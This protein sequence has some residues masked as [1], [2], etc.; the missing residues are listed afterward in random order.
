L[1]CQETRG[2][3]D[4]Y[5]DTELDLVKSLEI[6]KHLRECQACARVYES[7]LRLRSAIKDSALYFKAPAKLHK[8]IQSS[9]RE[10]GQTKA[11]QRAWQWRWLTLGASLAFVAL[12]VL[13]IWKVGFQPGSSPE[14]NLLAQE[15]VSN[16]VRSLMVD[17]LIDVQSSDQHTVK[18]WFDGKLDFSPP[19]TDLTAQGFSLIGG[20]LEY[21]ENRAVAAVVYQRRQ[22]FINLFI[23]PATQ[24]AETTERT[25]TRQG[26]NLIYWNK[27]GMTYWAVSDIN[28]SELQE[29]VRLV[30]SRT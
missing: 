18:P 6:E 26:Y 21:L 9:L 4:G 3:I 27:S 29:F 7:Q 10:E 24:H 19:V 12:I 22:H 30:Q 16:H 5:M 15:I 25:V 28:A 17:H 1:S 11:P 23:W 8:R 2:L 20:R 13:F 14:E